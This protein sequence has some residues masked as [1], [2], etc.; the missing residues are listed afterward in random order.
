MPQVIYTLLVNLTPAPSEVVGALQRIEVDASI[1]MASVL[2]LTFSIAATDT[3][4]WSILTDDTFAPLTPLQL[5]V[6]VDT[7][8]PE[9]IINAYVT[10]HA[11][12]YSDEPDGST[13]EVTAMD[14][15]VLMNLEEKVAAWP[16]M[17]D[18]T[19]A[20]LIF[21]Q[22]QLI[23]MVDTTSPVITEPEGTVMQR[24]TDMR[25]LQRLARRNGFDCYVQ[26]ESASGLD[27]AYFRAPDMLA[28]PQAVLNVNMAD[29]TNVSEFRVVHRMLRPTTARAFGIDARDVSA[30]SA[31]ASAVAQQ[32]LGS[33]DTLSQLST[34]PAVLLTDT[35]LMK[36]GD[37]QTLAQS[38]VDRAAWA[39]RA[40]GLVG[41]DVGVLRPGQL[42]N[43]RGAGTDLSGSYYVTHV[44]HTI[45]ESGYTQRFDA[46]RNAVGLTGSELFVDF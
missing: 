17:S 30:Q 21:G 8:L 32:R 41:D 1:E 22:H 40:E 13:L 10:G 37:L 43:I 18:S 14:A 28:M 25:F 26:P 12:A 9:T 15:T 7:G 45:D 11:V 39:V 5:R 38:V 46:R 4:D 23:P 29:Q 34:Q 42:V 16:N 27:A 44:T 3:G 2:R 33:R 36:S 24:G 19:I 6:Q 20:A 31:T 35:G